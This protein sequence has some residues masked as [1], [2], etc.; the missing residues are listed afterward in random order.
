MARRRLT[1]ASREDLSDARLKLDTAAHN[2]QAALKNPLDDEVR[3]AL[4]NA[5]AM[6]EQALAALQRVRVYLDGGD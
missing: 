4:A 1:S 6:T 2:V 3:E 5:A